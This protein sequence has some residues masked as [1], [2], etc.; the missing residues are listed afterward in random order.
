M[1]NCDVDNYGCAGGYLI[2]AID[3]LITEGVATDTCVPYREDKEDC[4]FQ[5]ENKGIIHEEDKEHYI[6]H[7]CKSGSFKVHT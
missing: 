2:P 5:C 1:V 6:K 7:Y 3:F 4:N